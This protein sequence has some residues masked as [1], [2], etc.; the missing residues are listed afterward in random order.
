MKQG[1]KIS[2][3]V[4]FY[5]ATVQATI[6]LVLSRMLTVW[7]TLFSMVLTIQATMLLAV[8]RVLTVWA[9]LFSMVV[10][11]QAT[12]LLAVSQVLTVRVTH[13]SQQQQ[14][15]FISPHNIQ[16]IKIYDNNTDDDRGAG[17]PK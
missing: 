17:C 4:I 5:G 8:S 16:E 15:H 14:Q 9:T 12:M 6:L 13:R 11:V 3:K 7:A 1:N 2:V 10:T